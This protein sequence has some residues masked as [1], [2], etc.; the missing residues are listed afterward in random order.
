MAADSGRCLFGQS[1][2]DHVKT[3]MAR[4]HAVL[5]LSMELRG[6]Q[7]YSDYPGV[8]TALKT[9]R[10]SISTCMQD[11]L[12]HEDVGV[13]LP[14]N[15]GLA[16]KMEM[17]RDANDCLIERINSEIDEAAG[18]QR[19]GTMEFPQAHITTVEARRSVLP[20]REDST[21][22]SSMILMASRN[23]QKPQLFFSEKVDNSSKRPFVP[24][25]K[26]KPNS[27][28]P[29]AIMVCVTKNGTEYFSHPY[30]YELEHWS[31]NMQTLGVP[32]QPVV[33]PAVSDTPL[34]MID[35]ET[36]LLAAIEELKQCSHIAVDVE[37]HAFRSYLGLTSLVQ[38][39]SRTKDYIID[40]IK[41]RGR[42]SRL[43]EVFTHPKITKVL[44]GAD[45][46]VLWL[47]R[48]CGVYLVNMFDTHVAAVLLE[49]PQRSL[50]ALLNTF[51]NVQADK[52]Y[53]RADWR[54]RPL[55]SSF[56]EYA[57]QD[58]HYLLYIHD[59]LHNL[60][61]DRAN[62]DTNLLQA[63]YDR[64]TALCMQRYEKPVVTEESYL[65][66][67]TRSRKSFNN[68]QLHA[69]Q[70]LFLWRDRTARE[71]DESVDFV[72]P[73]HMLLHMA[74]VLPKEVQGI[75]AC[76][77][78]IPA[79]VKTEL[80]ALHS[81]IRSAREQPL[82]KTVRSRIE[83]P[84]TVAE[85]GG[86]GARCLHDLSCVEDSTSMPCLLDGEWCDVM[87]C[88]LDGDW[89][90]VMPCLLDGDWCDVMPCLLD[91]EWCDVMPCLLDGEWCDV[92]PCL[93]D[94]DWFGVMPC[95]LDGEWCDVMPCL[96][97]GLSSK[98]NESLFGDLF[99]E[100]PIILKIKASSDLLGGLT[101]SSTSQK[102][103]KPV[104]AGQFLSPFQ[105]Y[106][107]YVDS[108]EKLPVFEES[109]VPDKDSSVSEKEERSLSEI[110]GTEDERV[111]RL[112]DHFLALAQNVPCPKREP[113]PKD[114]DD[115]RVE[116]LLAE[117]RSNMMK[118]T[119][120]PPVFKASSHLTPAV[121]GSEDHDSE[122]DTSDSSDSSSDSEAE[123]ESAS[124]R[125]AQAPDDGVRSC[126]RNSNSSTSSNTSN[127]HSED[128]C[129]KAET[130]NQ[131]N[132]EEPCS[133]GRNRDHNT[134]SSS[135][136]TSCSSKSGSRGSGP[137]PFIAGTRSCVP[138]TMLCEGSS[139]EL[140]RKTDASKTRCNK[141]PIDE[142]C[143]SGKS[144][145]TQSSETHDAMRADSSFETVNKK[146]SNLAVDKKGAGRT[147]NA[148]GADEA[149]HLKSAK[150]INDSNN[151]NKFLQKKKTMLPKK[152]TL[153]EC[154]TICDLT[155]VSD[156]SIESEPKKQK[157]V[158]AKKRGS[159]NKKLSA[160]PE[161]N[162]EASSTTTNKKRKSLE[163]EIEPFSYETA[164][165]KMF[166]TKKKKQRGAKKGRGGRG[167]GAQKKRRGTHGGRS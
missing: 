89:C 13:Q 150:Q 54:I 144:N 77:N 117:V 127:S 67:Y 145:L 157:R 164:D 40:P 132:P 53:Q 153:E 51:C 22:N 11:I 78:P 33:P 91:G 114:E 83:I 156:I 3:G 57:R 7:N 105:R 159:K 86:S 143:R 125:H 141:S 63:V 42:L 30:Q 5:K 85:S 154:Q 17:I 146:G 6:L 155:E 28:K 103:G 64:S 61:L 44:H 68:K 43:N 20:G 23:V 113:R 81:I 26:D 126:S 10:S 31:P 70:Q 148:K 151:A 109:K 1:I 82:R 93:L 123:D 165:F 80:L 131:R 92:M 75:M 15:F 48:D 122:D 128:G 25:I 18:I 142:D 110:S 136:S 14:S 95:L 27:L 163:M 47:Q 69:L 88:L 152:R 100:Q 149:V 134:S 72:L 97:D 135:T 29:L 74:E 158:I 8:I 101:P 129:A 21:L 140:E 50:A 9:F 38:V 102:T 118:A 41:L 49:F 106:R 59:L 60:L 34:Q 79:L 94:G 108:K 104:T 161:E 147:V 46:D 16:D 162:T 2:D 160:K 137:A 32:V 139:C 98:V 111:S 87:P 71:H 116:R 24:I 66:L 45:S 107:L 12:R 73:R 121:V 99:E 55:P 58:T 166:G 124:L 65:P 167:G 36:S 115:L 119:P 19:E 96:L 112:R 35:S 90:D 39:S 130:H 56:I 4:V 84:S 62:G 133:T 76:C 138:E 120:P 37:H 52:R